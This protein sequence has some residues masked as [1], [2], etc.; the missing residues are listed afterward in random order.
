MRGG[1]LGHL[2]GVGRWCGASLE[3]LSQHFQFTISQPFDGQI[4]SFFDT[5]RRNRKE[6][7]T[8]WHSTG[9]SVG[10][11][12]WRELNGMSVPRCGCCRSLAFGCLCRRCMARFDAE[13]LRRG[14]VDESL[15]SVAS[16]WERSEWV[17]PVGEGYEAAAAWYERRCGGGGGRRRKT[18]TNGANLGLK[19]AGGKA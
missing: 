18:G 13:R 2:A 17:T 6:I 4:C 15:R 8:A 7:S 16:E 14:L 10:W 11:R 1:H 19:N 9:V 12:V 5:K 3:V